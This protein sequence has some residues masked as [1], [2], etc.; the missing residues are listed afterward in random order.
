MADQPAITLGGLASGLDTNSIIQG[1]VKASQ[2]PIVQKQT[3]A[4]GYRA[5]ISAMSSIGTNLAK[6]QTAAAALADMQSAASYRATSSSTAIAVSADSTAQ[7]G[8]FSI[9]VNSLATEQRTYSKQ[10]AA[11]GTG[12]GLSGSFDITV[13]GTTKT[14]NVASTDT[15][16]NVAANINGIGGRF[17]A[18]VFYDGTAYRLQVRGL[19]TGSANA[20]TFDET[21]LGGTN[22]DLAGTIGDATHGKTVQTAGNASITVEGS[23]SFAGFTVTSAT[24]QFASVVPGVTLAV[25]QTTAAGSPVTVSVASDGTAVQDKLTTFAGAYNLVISQ[26]HSTTGFGTAAAQV[27]A[28]KGDATLRSIESQLRQTLQKV[29]GSGSTSILAQIGL[30]STRDGTLIFDSS[31]F[32]SAYSADPTAVQKLLARP[33]LSSTGG[34]MKDFSDLITSVTQAITGSMATKTTYFSDQASRLDTQ[35]TKEQDR[36]DNYA[37]QLRKQFT[38]MEQVYS[39]NQTLMSQLTKQFG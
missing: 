16:D 33:P 4:A 7:P 17:S 28:L 3:Q 11:R 25:T 22:F 34:V 19:D 39:Q 36:L 2:G 24:N 13:N 6:L 37:T 27:D 5:A 9:A 10:F 12:L 15:L 1:L 18:S 30:K 8:A 23:T 20:L 38:Q 21:N 32:Q 29:A 14:I 35:V 26:I 31:K